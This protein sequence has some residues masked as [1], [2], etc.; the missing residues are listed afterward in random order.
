MKYLIRAL[1]MFAAL[2]VVL[3]CDKEDDPLKDKLKF[4]VTLHVTGENLAGL[5][6]EMSYTS[7]R[8]TLTDPKPGPNGRETYGAQVDATYDLGEFG[9]YDQLVATIAMRNVTCTARPPA[10]SRLRL[11]VLID[12]VLFD[13]VELNGATP[14]TISCSQPYWLATI[15]SN[16]DDWDD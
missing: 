8:N 12:G 15:D 1:L 11:D 9:F 6:A 10:N 7:V 4:K 5:G 16:G 2:F 14:G 3:S 13:R